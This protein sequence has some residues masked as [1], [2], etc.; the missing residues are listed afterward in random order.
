[1]HSHVAA[2][3]QQQMGV[4]GAT[5]CYWVLPG[6]CKARMD[7]WDSLP[8]PAGQAHEGSMDATLLLLL[9]SCD[10]R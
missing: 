9:L 6:A 2:A 3:G 4:L 10:C 8:V 1:V 5:G 7:G